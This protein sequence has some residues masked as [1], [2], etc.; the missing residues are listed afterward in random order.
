LAGT[1]DS[2]VK[3]SDEFKITLTEIKKFISSLFDAYPSSLLKPA[4]VQHAFGGLRP[5]DKNVLKLVQ[6]GVDRDEMVNTSRDE[7]IVDHLTEEWGGL[8][9]INN[10]FSVVGIKYT[11]FRSVGERVVKLLNDREFDGAIFKFKS[12]ES[13]NQK[14]FDLESVPNLENMMQLCLDSNFQVKL[15]ELKSLRT[16][17]GSTS[18]YILAGAIENSRK[19]GLNSFDSLLFSKVE[20]AVRFEH[21]KKLSDLV[22]RRIPLSQLGFPGHEIVEKVSKFAAVNLGWSEEKRVSEVNEVREEFTFSD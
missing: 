22:I 8:P 9:K 15:P 6:S 7:D 12:G 10:F 2:I 16:I 3:G 17:Y 14:F 18:T 5:V 20:Y 21:A 4:H 13:K 19:H 11:T 1:T